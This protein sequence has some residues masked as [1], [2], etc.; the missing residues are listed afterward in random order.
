MEWREKD[1]E[2][3]RRDEEARRRGEGEPKRATEECLD[4][5]GVDRLKQ[6]LY[7]GSHSGR[8]VLPVEIGETLR[9]MMSG[10]DGWDRQHSM[11]IQKG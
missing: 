9:R 1:E 2:E 11:K 4:T 8:L 6:L 7:L 3:K 5:R 10:G